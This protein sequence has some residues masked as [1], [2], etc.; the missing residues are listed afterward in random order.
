M[1]N[2]TAMRGKHLAC[3]HCRSISRT[4]VVVQM[5]MKTCPNGWTKEYDGYL[6]A[7]GKQHKGEYICVD[8]DMQEPNGQVTFGKSNDGSVPELKE[9]TVLCGSLPCVTFE[10]SK[11]IDCVV[12]TL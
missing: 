5:A 3:S 1:E 11:P 2:F 4:A 6:M 10:E 9:V 12:C 8:R 7:P